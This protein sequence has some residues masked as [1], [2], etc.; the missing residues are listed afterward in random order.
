MKRVVIQERSTETER[1]RWFGTVQIRSSALDRAMSLFSLALG[2]VVIILLWNGHYTRSVQAEGILIP[3][4]GLIE[5]TAPTS[6]TISQLSVKQG[7]AVRADDILVTI[8]S[9]Q[10]IAALGKTESSVTDQLVLQRARIVAD[11]EDLGT[12][13][14]EKRRAAGRAIEFLSAELVQIED[15]LTNQLQQAQSARTLVERVRPAANLGNVSR[16]QESELEHNALAAEARVMELKR[17]RLQLQQHVAADQNDLIQLPIVIAA[18]RHELERRA[19]DVSQALAHNEVHRAS[20]LR[21]PQ[22]GIITAVVVHGGESI[23]AGGSLL[24]LMPRDSRLVAQV[25]LA[26]REAGFVTKESNVI[27]RYQAFPYQKFGLYKG[28][29]T[30]VSQSALPPAQ[31]SLMIEHPIVEPMYRVEVMLDSQT[32]NTYGVRTQLK[33]GMAVDAQIQL[34]RRSLFEWLVQPLY[35]PARRLLGAR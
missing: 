5:L 28:S 32:V 27:L 14:K 35:G 7:D 25:F 22:D 4:S 19:S 1:L 29:V 21:A 16:L 24:T 30:S 23:G 17:E 9:E 26:S 15:Q 18:Q 10:S 34:D 6:G 12:L 13:E 3:A 2:I 11:L 20:V 8:S 33:P 31:V